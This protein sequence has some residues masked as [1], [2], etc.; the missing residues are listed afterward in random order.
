ML[1]TISVMRIMFGPSPGEIK[2]A[3]FLVVP[4][5]VN[6]QEVLMPFL[7]RRARHAL[8]GLC[9][10]AMG[11]LSTNGGSAPAWAHEFHVDY[12]QPTASIIRQELNATEFYL[13]HSHAAKP[14]DAT[15]YRRRSVNLFG[16]EFS[17]QRKPKP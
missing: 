4:K 10:A 17:L 5:E 14:K 16:W 2:M 13:T 6:P 11:T 9:L 8:Y 7:L 3:P 15:S 1:A 12:S